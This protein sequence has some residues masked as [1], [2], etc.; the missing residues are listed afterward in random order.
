MFK[1]DEPTQNMVIISKWIDGDNRQE[2]KCKGT[3]NK[4]AQ[5]IELTRFLYKWVISNS[6][7]AIYV[8][9]Y[10]IAD[11]IRRWQ[12]S[13][14]VTYI[15]I[16]L[17]LGTIDKFY[18]KELLS[19]HFRSL[20]YVKQPGGSEKRNCCWSWLLLLPLFLEAFSPLKQPTT[21]EINSFCNLSF[22]LQIKLTPTFPFNRYV[23]DISWDQ[24][25]SIHNR[26][27]QATAKLWRKMRNWIVTLSHI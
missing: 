6:P 13:A 14:L 15:K 4:I 23:V 9:Q 22:S 5:R 24:N 10:S 2:I 19:I 17:I 7:V 25:V 21:A 27:E 12:L 26:Q 16:S 8:I 3:Y 11:R 1:Y 20:P 18:V